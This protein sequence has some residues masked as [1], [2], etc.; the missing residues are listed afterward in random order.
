MY[1]KDSFF[2]EFVAKHRERPQ[3]FTRERA[4]SFPDVTILVLGHLRCSIHTELERFFERF[5]GLPSVSPSAFSQARL[6]LLPSAFIALRQVVVDQF[7]KK[8]GTFKLEGT[9]TPSC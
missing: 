1:Q 4:L 6:K 9:Q 8:G 7:Y 5:Q 2:K 3:D